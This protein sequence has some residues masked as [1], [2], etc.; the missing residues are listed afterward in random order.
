[1]IIKYLKRIEGKGRKKKKDNINEVKRKVK[2]N[3]HKN[4]KEG[5]RR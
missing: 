2:K 1:M 5:R 3:Y 4:S